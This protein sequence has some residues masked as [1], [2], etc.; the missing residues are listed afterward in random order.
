MTILCILE[1]KNYFVESSKYFTFLIYVTCQ[2]EKDPLSL[3]G[4]ILCLGL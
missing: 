3:L 4:K 1:A 2:L